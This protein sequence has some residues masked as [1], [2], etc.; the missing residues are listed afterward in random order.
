M[1]RGHGHRPDLNNSNCNSNNNHIVV[2]RDVGGGVG[3][4][5]FEI[6]DASVAASKAV[7]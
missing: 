4:V 5:D 6:V 2:D 3:V 1:L 7:G